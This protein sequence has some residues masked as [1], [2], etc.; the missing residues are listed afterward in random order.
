MY[1]G[2]VLEKDDCVGR[3]ADDEGGHDDDR[4]SSNAQLRADHARVLEVRVADEPARTQF[5]AELRVSVSAPNREASLRATHRQRSLRELP[6][7][8]VLTAL[9]AESILWRTER[10]DCACSISA[11]SAEDGRLSVTNY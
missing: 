2:G 5:Y 11:A 10:R 1:E 7:M 9:T 4:R 8:A 6:T 3:P